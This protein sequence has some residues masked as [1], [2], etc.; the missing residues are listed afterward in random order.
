[1]RSRGV[2]SG[3]FKIPQCTSHLGIGLGKAAPKAR[4]PKRNHELTPAELET[5]RQEYL[6]YD[7]LRH[8]TPEYM[9]Y[10]RL[11]GQ[12]RRRNAKEL[13]LC[14]DCMMTAIP[15]QTR[16]ETCA[17]KN[18]QSQRR[19]EE[20]ATRQRDQAPGQTSMF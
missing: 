5:K 3:I 9:E 8:K 6:E 2:L 10:S 20:R 18:R 12:E 15:V 13:G 14:R 7:R 17:E 16:C 19:S 11:K 4:K 1:M